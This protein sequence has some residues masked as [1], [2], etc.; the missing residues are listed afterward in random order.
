VRGPPQTLEFGGSEASGLCDWKPWRGRPFRNEGTD[1][2]DIREEAMW[3]VDP[4][5]GHDYETSNYITT[6]AK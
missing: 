1:I 4:L 5:P 3:H 2:T 6:I